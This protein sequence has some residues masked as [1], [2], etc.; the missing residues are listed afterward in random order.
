MG[1]SSTSDCNVKDVGTKATVKRPDP[2]RTLLRAQVIWKPQP[3][4]RPLIEPSKTTVNDVI[5][6]AQTTKTT[7]EDIQD[8]HADKEKRKE[9]VIVN[10]HTTKKND[11]KGTTVYNPATSQK[12]S[13]SAV[14][15]ASELYPPTLH[16]GSSSSSNTPY[17]PGA[18]ASKKTYAATLVGRPPRR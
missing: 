13:S 9:R 10:I 4:R 2:L 16:M 18:A 14:H 5:V 17:D 7:P 12:V 3:K 11:N 8:Q 1:S 15:T 6:L